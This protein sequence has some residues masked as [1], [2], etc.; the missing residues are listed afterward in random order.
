VARRELGAQRLI[1]IED[2]GY[3][4]KIEATEEDKA[5]VR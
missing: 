2:L 5:R 4:E 1:H 3:V